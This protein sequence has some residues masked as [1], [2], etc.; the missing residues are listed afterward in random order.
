LGVPIIYDRDLPAVPA[1]KVALQGSCN[2]AMMYGTRIDLTANTFE[3]ICRTRVPY[4]ELYT[5][6]FRVLDRTKDRIIEGMQKREDLIIF[7]AM[8]AAATYNTAVTDTGALSK[9]GLAMAASQVEKNRL[10]VGSILMTAFGVSGI[11]RFQ[12]LNL[13]Q[14]GMQIIRESGYLGQMWGADFYV[15]DQLSNGQAYLMSTPKFNAW[16]PIRK[17]TDIIPA[18]QNRRVCP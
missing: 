10:V 9:S 5:R 12:Y 8:A 4:S 7:S 3:T 11:R 2:Q 17:D 16:M 18:E 1:I 15:T 6:R 14:V 13:D